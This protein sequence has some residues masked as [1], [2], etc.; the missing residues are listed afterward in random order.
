M[1]APKRLGVD[2]PASA[3]LAPLFE[4]LRQLQ[5][6]DVAMKRALPAELHDR[7]RVGNFREGTLILLVADP[8]WAT[9]LRL[10][11]DTLPGHPALAVHAQIRRIT[12]KVSPSTLDS[13]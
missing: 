9:R 13:P 11:A 12:V 3:E 1:P 2:L 6:F 4:H 5:S 10:I 8:I 7:V